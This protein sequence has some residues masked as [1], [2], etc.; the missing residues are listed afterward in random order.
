MRTLLIVVGDDGAIRREQRTT[1][2]QYNRFFLVKLFESCD[3]GLAK[4]RREKRGCSSAV[5]ER[6]EESGVVGL[7]LY[8]T[9]TSLN[10][11]YIEQCI[12]RLDS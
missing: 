5:R 8:T 6:Q 7:I 2:V 9:A 11:P 1:M 10:G 12:A 4:W 3:C